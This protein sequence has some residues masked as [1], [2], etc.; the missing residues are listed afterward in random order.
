[1]GSVSNPAAAAA[2]LVTWTGC[3][4]GANA[5]GAWGR[6]DFSD[7]YF[8]PGLEGLEPASSPSGSTRGWLAGGQVGCNYQ[9]ATNWVIGLEA[10]ADWANI[11]GSSDP[12]FGG[13]AVFKAHTDWLGGATGRVGYAVN[14]WLIYAKGGAAWAGDKYSVP[15]TY[16][17]TAFDFAGSETRSGWTGGAG[18]EWALGQNWSAKLEYAYYDFGSHTLNLT[19]SGVIGTDLGPDPSAIKQRVQTV[20]FGVNFRL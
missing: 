7:K 4:L 19:D 11:P 10:A 6:K 12:F 20:T 18:I 14:N 1:V 15:G 2:P 17:N 3:Y 13:K 16:A 8:T 5:G 9:F